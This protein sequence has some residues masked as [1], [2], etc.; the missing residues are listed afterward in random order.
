MNLGFAEE[1][2]LIQSREFRVKEEKVMN[3]S[4]QYL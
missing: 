2:G 3:A 4:S 1:T